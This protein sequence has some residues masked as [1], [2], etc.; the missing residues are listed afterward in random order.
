MPQKRLEIG[1]SLDCP[2]ATPLLIPAERRPAETRAAIKPASLKARVMR[3]AHDALFDRVH[4]STLIYNTCWEDPR[5]D[6]QLLELQPDSRVVMITS[7]GCNTLDYLLDDPA[8]IHA[9]DVNP[10]QNAL[11]QLKIA[12]LDHGDHAELFRL[13]G[14]G[15]R[16]DFRS[17]LER[18][19]PRL[20]P[21]A[22]KFWDS[23]LY[24]FECTPR[25]P[26][27]YY[28]GAAGR[29]A[30]ILLQGLARSNP[31]VKD[32]TERLLN[33][34]SL[35]EQSA[36][37][38]RLQAGFWNAFNSWLLNQPLTMAMLGV[39]RPQIRIIEENFAGGIN[40]YI[41]AKMEYVLTK[42]PMRDNYFWR[43]YATGRYTAECCPNYLLAEN[44]P[45]LRE[46]T[47]RV[48]TH[49]T[50]VAGFLR[51]NP[52][53][54]THYVLLDHQDWLASHDVEGL[55]EEWNLVLANSRPGTRILM[56]SASPEIDFIPDPVRER[57]KFFEELTDRLHLQDR[58]G[59]YGSTLLAEVR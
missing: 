35:D 1:V 2:G 58:V 21:Y 8:E 34:K 47:A 43:V 10:R 22:N 6:R 33:A 53:E 49:S 36:F 40:G 29:V 4:S 44:F 26:S 56:R 24:Y 23:K 28:R 9:V 55:R 45:L 42:L 59:T 19:A 14:E 41:R 11:L 15:T 27:F 32:L 37:Y 46:R 3:R 30:W 31:Q 54:Y 12:L 48:R 18:L 57:L 20:P 13:F 7:A 17:L 50:S 39:P 52:G 25:A 38:D 51:Q 5:L 16:P